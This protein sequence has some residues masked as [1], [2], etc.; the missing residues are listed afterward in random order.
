VPLFLTLFVAFWLGWGDTPAPP[1]AP[2]V[3][4]LFT[5]EGCSDCPA[6]DTLLRNLESQQPIPG[7][8]IIPLGLHVDYWNE[9]GWRDRFSTHGFT[10]RQ[11]MYVDR[12][13]LESPYTPQMVVDGKLQ[14]VGND[15]ASVRKAL[16]QRTGVSKASVSAKTVS[17]GVLDVSIQ[18]APSGA[19]IMLAITESDLSTNVSGGENRGRE[20]RHTAVVRV[21]NRVG[22]VRGDGFSGQVHVPLNKSWRAENLRAVIF[23]QAHSGEIAGAAVVSL[24]QWRY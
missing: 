22:S 16:L 8:E 17:L 14:A 20:L 7:I 21:L 15:A 6:A 18:G 19:D 12:M 23:V 3:V 2:V 13:R 1:R 5:S 9:L 24:A 11:E 4:E 10:L